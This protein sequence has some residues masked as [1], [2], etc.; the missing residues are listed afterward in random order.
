MGH[1][2]IVKHKNVRL[3]YQA[4]ATVATPSFINQ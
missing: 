3:S 4:Y 1:Y 2:F